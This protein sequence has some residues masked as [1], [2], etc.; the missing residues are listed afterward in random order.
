MPPGCNSATKV[1]AEHAVA[2]AAA[3]TQELFPP[4][5]KALG[6]HLH[7]G[8]RLCK[9]WICLQPEHIRKIMED[10]LRVTTPQ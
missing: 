1:E 5:A 6:Y 9:D 3:I 7:D 4:L 8:F 2:V 10:S